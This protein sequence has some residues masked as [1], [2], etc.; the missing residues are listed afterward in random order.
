MT[1]TT[2]PEPE[3]NYLK[4]AISRIYCDDD[5][6]ILLGLTGRTGSGCSTAA[7]ILLA[8]Q[9]VIKHSLSISTEIFP[10]VSAEKLPV[11]R[12]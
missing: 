5:D 10:G 2:Q 9:T 3:R 6:F 12:V 7:N 8:S 11:E 1:D 4:S